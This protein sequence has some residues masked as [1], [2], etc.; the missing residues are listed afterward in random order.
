MVSSNELKILGDDFP[1]GAD[2]FRLKNIE[3]WPTVH[4]KAEKNANNISDNPP[5]NDMHSPI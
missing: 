2:E 1:W 4:R 3:F 5:Y